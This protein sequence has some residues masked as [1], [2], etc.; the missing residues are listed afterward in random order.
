M[1]CSTVASVSGTVFEW[2]LGSVSKKVM[3]K[4]VL[5]EL[6]KAHSFA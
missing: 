5:C 4:P 2:N 6:H 1:T 3:R